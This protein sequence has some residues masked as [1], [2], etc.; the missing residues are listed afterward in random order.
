MKSTRHIIL[1]AYFGCLS[2]M[3]SVQAATLSLADSPLYL[4]NRADPNVLINLSIESPM[5]G[6]GYN[7]QSDTAGCGGRPT[8]EGGFNIGTC[9]FA[10][11][12]YLGYF[13]PK[14][15]Y[16]YTSSRFEPSGATTATHECTGKWSG[17]FM[18]WVSMTA[19]D[20]FRW[21][22]TGGH[23]VPALDT[24]TL[25]V[26]ERANQTL[27]KGHIWYPVKKISASI[28]VA[29]S[30]VTPYS[31]TTLYIYNRGTQMDV[32]TTTATNEKAIDL[33]VRVKVCDSA[34]GL[35]ST[36]KAYGTSNKPEGLIQRNWDRMR[37]AVTSYLLDNS[38]SRDGGVLRSKMKYTGPQKY[39]VG[40]GMV[41]NPNSEWSATD[42]TFI[43]NPDPTDASASA[44]ANSGVINY[45]NKFGAN[46]YK[47]KDPA[48]ELFYEAI[49]YFK[50]LGPTPEYSS[51][52]T[53]T[54]K[55][56][57]PVITTWDDPI[58]FRCQKNFIV[59]I[60]DANPWLD[61][62][63]PGTFF[64]TPTI[65]GAASSTVTLAAGDY[66]PPSNPDP[67][68]NVTT[69]TNTV[70]ALEGLNGTSWV[71][72]GPWASGTASG[73][74]DGIGGG[75]DTYNTDCL[76][77]KTVAKLGEVMGTCG[78]PHKENSY[79]IA[80]L[81][82]Y[83]NTT[84]IRSD[85]TGKQT[86]ATYMI[87]TQEY[88]A[89]PLDGPRNML[90][91]A[92]KYGGFIDSNASGTPDLASE[93]DA[94]SDG[95]P[96]NYVLATQPDKLV[97][98]LSSAF[99]DIIARTG[100]SASVGASSTS[101]RSGTN[102]YQVIFNSGEWFGELIA[103]PISTAGVIGTAAWNAGTKLATPTASTRA[104]IT[105]N[106]ASADGVSFRWASLT[107]AQQATI[108]G[109]DSVT[110]AQDRLNYLRGDGTNETCAGACAAG[111]PFRQRPTNKLGDIV[112]S[113]PQHV[114][115]PSGQYELPQFLL[116]A[117][118]TDSDYLTFRS[119]NIGR[120]PV[121]YAGA[122][123]G[124]LHGFNAC[125]P[126]GTGCTAANQGTELLAYVPS[127]VY[128]NLRSLSLPGYTH[129]YFVDGS[130]TVADAKISGDWKTVLVGG[131]NAGGRGVF[132]LDVTTPSTFSEATAKNIVLWE[133]NDSHDTDMGYTYA[134]PLIAK[135]NNGTGTGKWAAIFGNGYNSASGIAKLFILYIEEGV[136]GTWNATDFVKID[137]K[138]GS[139]SL[140]NGLASVNAIDRNIDGTVDTI[141]AGD[142]LGNMW[143]FDVSDTN[144]NNWK[145]AFGSTPAP[146]PL[147][148]ACGGAC[149][150]SNYQPIT[151][152]PEVSFHPTDFNTTMVYFGTGKYIETSDPATTA[153]QT[154]YGI[155]DNN[156]TVSGRSTLL[157]Q[158]I[159]NTTIAG[160]DF[161]NLTNTAIDWTTHKGWYEDLPDTGERHTGNP[162]LLFGVLFY[163]TLIPTTDPCDVG[164]TGYLMAV[165][166]EN[167]GLLPFSIFDT[168]SSGTFTSSDI[169]VGGKKVGAVLG[170]TSILGPGTSGGTS[171]G[172]N[173]LTDGVLGSFILNLKTTAGRI[174]WRE[175]LD[176]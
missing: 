72:S 99:L 134:K 17:N 29:P 113:S 39:V 105:Y 126:V 167:G 64:T 162:K 37:F 135:M 137:T 43:T 166:P 103:Y 55:D 70:G 53:A 173:S 33:N 59:G 22:L 100:S 131:L 2:L 115:A 143:K 38:A 128:S 36:C 82:Y 139:V 87:D 140:P 52:L 1:F 16:T 47:D 154:F 165:N 146:A 6:A 120:T 106:P 118:L 86:I 14:K 124:M 98:G 65:T 111:Y 136:D 151:S 21:A 123:D 175:L 164:G 157:P 28:N 147:F 69:L 96:D 108:Q 20:E 127:S 51:G 163:N 122:N 132:A 152:R 15:C 5:V 117:Y 144:D 7:D 161:R 30:T 85:F 23:R 61:K 46:G 62:K 119:A 155:W 81:A 138:A 109:A 89:N 40:S 9:Y 44:V 67:D 48:G 141:Y 75:V 8:P 150:G 45:I 114:G 121:V 26:L 168:D 125:S 148:T 171:V 107:A 159:T 18:N 94:N 102:V 19:I 160:S 31:D 95:V 169:A 60:N 129:K 101:L 54:M 50:N 133:F 10:T 73:T 112:N 42:G 91:L 176:E 153:T 145:V 77:A 88:A 3:G 174:S 172:I 110:V 76:T 74:L 11:K 104:I 35:E 97:S 13:D 84:D 78:A 41:T 156:A 170:G 116:T 142:L 49:R 24:A 149:S 58:Q 93:W 34:A 12:T 90:W 130:P 83:A 79:Y 25:T 4:A 56:G 66:G 92:G 80:G 158:T 68:I 32:G 57:F 71:S 27:G 63:L